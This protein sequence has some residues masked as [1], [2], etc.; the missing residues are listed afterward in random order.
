M[1]QALEAEKRA[2]AKPELGRFV[3]RLVAL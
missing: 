1:L 2:R 3:R